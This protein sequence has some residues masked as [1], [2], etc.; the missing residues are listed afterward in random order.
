M[1]LP[2]NEVPRYTCKLPST[3]EV[4][5]YRPFLVKEEKVM[6][7]AIEGQNDDE[8]AQAVT[9]TVQNCVEPNIDVSSIPIFDFEYLYIYPSVLLPV[10]LLV[11]LAVM[12]YLHLVL[13]PDTLV[14]AYS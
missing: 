10:E 5:T 4:V 1:A 8:I 7:M 6:L 9:N 14:S 11:Y 3:G 13:L 2:I 12:F